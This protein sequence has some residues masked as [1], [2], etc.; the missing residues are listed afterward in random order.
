VKTIANSIE[1]GGSIEQ[2]M[3]PYLLWSVSGS[4]PDP[5]AQGPL[6]P[7][8]YAI[9]SAVA[10]PALSRVATASDAHPADQ[11]GRGCAYAGMMYV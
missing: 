10:R 3:I 9:S 6:P 4:T 5:T 1:G 2:P 7:Y 8:G 11:T